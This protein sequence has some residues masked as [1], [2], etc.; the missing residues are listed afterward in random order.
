M[1]ANYRQSTESNFWALIEHSISIL[2][3]NFNFIRD[4]YKDYP[5]C[6]LEYFEKD[7]HK[8][9]FEIRLAN[10]HTTLVCQ[11]DKN[12]ICNSVVLHI[13]NAH[14]MTKLINYLGDYYTYN[15]LKCRWELYECYLKIVEVN[16][17]NKETCLLFYQ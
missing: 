4:K 7:T 3:S 1:A 10:E 2:N 17:L 9:H 16:S 11:F 14:M 12:E 8:K 5:V 6:I 15:Y 13:D